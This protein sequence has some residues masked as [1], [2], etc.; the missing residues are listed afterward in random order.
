MKRFL[1][2]VLIGATLSMSQMSCIGSFGLFN[3][4]KDWNEGIGGKF[5]NELIFL[6]LWIIPVYEI[7]MAADLLIFN[8]IEFW[9]GSNPIAMNEGDMEQQ[10]VQGKDGNDYL[11]TATQNQFKIEEIGNIENYSI[12]QYTPEDLKWEVI[13]GNKRIKLVEGVKDREGKLT[14]EVML[15]TSPNSQMVYDL[16]ETSLAQLKNQLN[17][18]T[19]LYAKY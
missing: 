14:G 17:G 1:S 18:S 4:L 10:I 6:G 8:S 9:T 5:V 12:M 11:I 19:A 13:E 15:H 3:N 2:V 16:N 7:A